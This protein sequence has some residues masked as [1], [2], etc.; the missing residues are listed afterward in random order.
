MRQ[1]IHIFRK[2]ARHCWPYIAGVIAVTAVHT[3]REPLVSPDPQAVGSHLSGALLGMLMAVAWWL[4]I[5]AA[6]HEESTVGDRQF[7]VTRPYSWK[8]LL[9]AKVLFAVACL[10]LPLFISDCV[11]LAACMYNPFELLP[12]LLVRQC[13]FLGFLILPFVMAT[14]TRQTREFVLSGLA[15]YVVLII[16]LAAIA[17]YAAR[18]RGGVGFDSV[19]GGELASWA[20]AA[21]GLSL[22]MWQYARRRTALARTF[23]IAA[24]GLMLF[25]MGLPLLGTGVSLR[26]FPERD[27]LPRGIKVQL[28]QDSGMS[29]V[30]FSEQTFPVAGVSASIAGSNNEVRLSVQFSGWTG[31]A[32]TWNPLGVTAVD[33][34]TGTKLWTSSPETVFAK[35][36]Y[37]DGRESLAF[38]PGI[39]EPRPAKVDLQVSLYAMFYESSETVKLPD[40]DGWARAAGFGMFRLLDSRTGRLLVWRRALD[41]GGQGWMYSLGN[42]RNQPVASGFQA[43]SL[44]AS[45]LW[46]TMSPVDSYVVGQS[47]PY[48]D[49][50]VLTLSRLA[51]TRTFYNLKV[52]GVRL[53]SQNK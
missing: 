29:G 34:A 48:F 51:G 38:V 18:G 47:V 42:G 35:D 11:I 15:F 26:V 25:A 49:G 23:A 32:I 14:L 41:L 6:V 1:A 44:P 46:F 12:G 4:A 16:A 28:A 24:G 45:P 33:P 27:S 20:V 8:S 50:L 31:R 52:S 13:W 3:W 17:S 9:G 43:S 36:T 19:S 21:V 10:A 53:K 37:T 5:G 7:W 39:E 2:D 40:W 30:S 22:A